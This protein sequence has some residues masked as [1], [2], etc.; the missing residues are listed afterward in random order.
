[1]ILG[2]A[3]NAQITNKAISS[4]ATELSADDAIDWKKL[5]LQEAQALSKETGKPIFIDISAVWC[6]YCKKMKRNVYTQD[7][8]VSKVNEE[9]IALAID[10][11]KGEGV[12]LVKK[13]KVR[14]Y[15]TQFILDAE[16]NIL[17]RHDG[18]MNEGK[19]LSF[20]K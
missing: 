2:F 10:G 17:N 20:L 9:Y 12:E 15:P 7:A 1:M 5:S 11:E 18:Y 14:G 13:H 19:L 8:V 4:N 6:G 16:G 3:I